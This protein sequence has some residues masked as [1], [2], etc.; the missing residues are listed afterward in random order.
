MLA[1]QVPPVGKHGKHLWGPARDLTG[2]PWRG[3]GPPARVPS[4]APAA[5][6]HTPFG[7]AAGLVY[8]V[9]RS[10]GKKYL[11]EQPPDLRGRRV[12]AGRRRA[13][14]RPTGQ[15]IP[16]RTAPGVSL[17]WRASIIPGVLLVL[18]L[19]GGGPL[20]GLLS[21]WGPFSGSVPQAVRCVGRWDR[22]AQARCERRQA[23]PTAR[24]RR[25]LER[26]LSQPLSPG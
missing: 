6:T 25:S 16:R 17:R 23:P 2:R 18:G 14:P 26:R 3:P 9:V 10:V 24:T 7:F 15:D 20:A 13:G 12:D 8:G 1:T 11:S 19:F 22:R 21:R 5:P 4:K